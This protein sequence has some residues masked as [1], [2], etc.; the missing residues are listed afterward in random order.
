METPTERAYTGTMKRFAYALL[1]AVVLSSAMASADENPTNKTGALSPS[2]K[3]FVAAIQSDLTARFPTAADAE[4]AGYFRYTNEDSTGAISYA[5]L[6]WSSADPKHPSQLW[7][8]KDGKLLGADFSV[9]TSESAKRPVLW[10]VDPGRW[11]EFDGHIHWIA[12]DPSTGK[13]SYDHWAM[14]PAFVKAGGNVANPSATTLVAMK[15]VPAAK[16]VVTIFEF[17]SV[18]D[19]I[20]WVKPNPNGAFAEKNPNVKP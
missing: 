18:W 2:E 6:E 8:D 20:V 19:L 10:G 1:A 3:A 9:L 14:N 17:P 16:D 15:K 13:L 4:K 5:N 7:Y 11:Y 12:R